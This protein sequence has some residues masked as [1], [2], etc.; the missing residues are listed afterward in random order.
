MK[1]DRGSPVDIT[2]KPTLIHFYKDRDEDGRNLAVVFACRMK[3]DELERTESDLVRF[4]AH[5]SQA[6]FKIGD[7]NDFERAVASRRCVMVKA[8]PR[9]AMVVGQPDG[10]SRYRMD[11]PLTWDK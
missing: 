5:C 11:G 3:W 6:V 1:R 8:E 4:C 10:A 9:G 2:S 7:I